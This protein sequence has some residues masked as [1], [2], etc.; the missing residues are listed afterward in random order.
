MRKRDAAKVPRPP[1]PWA[2][3]VPCIRNSGRWPL[4]RCCCPNGTMEISPRFQP[5]ECNQPQ[6]AKSRRDDVGL[7]R[8][9]NVFCFKYVL[10]A[11]YDVI[12]EAGVRAHNAFGLCEF[13]TRVPS[14]RWDFISLFEM[15]PRL[16]PG[17]ICHSPFGTSTNSFQWATR[18]RRVLRQLPAAGKSTGVPCLLPGKCFGSGGH[19]PSALLSLR[20]PI[21]ACPHTVPCQS[22]GPSAP[23]LSAHIDH[24]FSTFYTLAQLLHR[25][26]L[27]IPSRIRSHGSAQRT[28]VLE[29]SAAR[30]ASLGVALLPADAVPTPGSLRAGRLNIALGGASWCILSGRP[31]RSPLQVPPALAP[32][33]ARQCR[34][35]LRVPSAGRKWGPRMCFVY[36]A[37]ITRSVGLRFERW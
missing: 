7:H 19:R 20:C 3:S 24:R 22:A 32:I 11:E 14:S 4:R 8:S 26:A 28:A 33:R 15:F 12:R 29:Q 25:T 16:K 30:S 9:S 10:G 23:C 21:R 17:A 13:E 34:P 1:F 18:G 35:G 27:A 36:I 2:I 37:D 6:P 5:G 31:A